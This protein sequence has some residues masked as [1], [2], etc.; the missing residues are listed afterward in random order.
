MAALSTL[1]SELFPHPDGPTMTH[2]I[3]WSKDSLSWIIFLICAA[4]STRKK[5]FSFITWIVIKGVVEMETSEEE[6]S[7]LLDKKR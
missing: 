6:I 5:G 7:R 4:S 2:P 1:H 3:R